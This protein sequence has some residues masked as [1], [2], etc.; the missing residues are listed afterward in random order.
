MC[1]KYLNAN[2]ADPEGQIGEIHDPETH[3]IPI[4]CNIA[5]GKIE[6]VSVFGND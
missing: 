5:K 2:G 3:I 1:F 4:V 6:I